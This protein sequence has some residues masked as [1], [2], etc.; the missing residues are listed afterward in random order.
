MARLTIDIS[1]VGYIYSTCP[2]VSG[3]TAST[4][5]LSISL[6]PLYAI[7]LSHSNFM[8]QEL[9]RGVD[10]LVDVIGCYPGTRKFKGTN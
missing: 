1:Q 10:L 9:H 6:M 5:L 3:R 8:F 7:D 2:P 4:L